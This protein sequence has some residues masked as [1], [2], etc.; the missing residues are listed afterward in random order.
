MTPHTPVEGLVAIAADMRRDIELFRRIH[1][2]L[3]NRAGATTEAGVAHAEAA[4]H[5]YDAVLC[6]SRYA[7]R[8]ASLPVEGWSNPHWF[9]DENGCQCRNSAGEECLSFQCK[10]AK[11]A[12]PQDQRQGNEQGGTHE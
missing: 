12:A 7:D 2:S 6:L 4:L 9:C 5:V 8:L 3:Q 11:P 10:L 1:V